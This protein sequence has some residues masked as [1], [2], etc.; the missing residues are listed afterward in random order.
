M[1]TDLMTVPTNSSEPRTANDI[2]AQVN[3]IQEVMQSVMKNGVHYGTIP[4]CGDKPAL[5]KPG[6]EKLMMTFRMAVD[7]QIE[8]FSNDSHC[9]YRVLAKLT[10]IP[11]GAFLGQ[12]IGECSSDEEKYAWRRVAVEQEWH[13]ADP[14]DRREKW[15][16]GKQNSSYKVKQIRTNPA[17]V[18]NTVLKMAKKRA[19]IDAVLTVTAASDIFSQDIEEL[20]EAPIAVAPNGKTLKEKLKEQVTQD[21]A[22]PDTTGGAR[23]EDGAGS[24][25]VSGLGEQAGNGT[26]QASDASASLSYAD[27]IDRLN[28]AQS[29]KEYADTMNAIDLADYTPKERQEIMATKEAAKKRLAKK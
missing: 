5:L 4:G 26:Q 1:T 18:A 6:A 21:G 16:R 2:R 23:Q 15:M 25:P 28:Q 12:G 19:L 3:R 11:T 17:D 8:D 13:E 29:A 9:R 14:A 10:F 27:V 7:P 20:D 24:Q 22:A